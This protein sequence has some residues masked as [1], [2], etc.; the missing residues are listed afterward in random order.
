MADEVSSSDDDE[1]EVKVPPVKAVTFAPSTKNVAKPKK[2]DLYGGGKGEKVAEDPDMQATGTFKPHREKAP[3]SQD[4]LDAFIRGP[5]RYAVWTEAQLQTHG[6]ELA[7][8]RT[9]HTLHVY[10]LVP[11]SVGCPGRLVHLQDTKGITL[12]LTED[13]DDTGLEELHSMPLVAAEIADNIVSDDAVAIVVK[14]AA[15]RTHVPHLLTRMV[16]TLVLNR[17]PS[18]KSAMPDFSDVPKPWRY[19]TLWE[20]PKASDVDGL[21]KLSE[22]D[23]CGSEGSGRMT[24]WY[25]ANQA[26]ATAAGSSSGSKRP[27]DAPLVKKPKKA[28]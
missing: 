8:A 6:M 14:P 11:S 27:A 1:C 12:R 21:A 2:I 19:K 23:L 25:H 7:N 26:K 13:A 5:L 4:K 17:R 3:S 28:K 9:L 22:K 20:A 18:L 15:A 10:R 16:V 24:R